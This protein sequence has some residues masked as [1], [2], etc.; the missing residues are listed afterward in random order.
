VGNV[1]SRSSEKVIEADD[2][3]T[4]VDQSLAEMGPYEPGAPGNQYPHA[5]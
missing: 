4:T 3:F 5:G 1:A 2:F